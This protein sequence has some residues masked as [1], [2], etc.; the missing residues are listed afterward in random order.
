MW[1]PYVCV[2]VCLVF[3]DLSF[4]VRVR[5]LFFMPLPW[6]SHIHL[7]VHL[8]LPKAFVTSVSSHTDIDS[9]VMLKR[10]KNLSINPTYVLFCAIMPPSGSLEQPD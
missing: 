8:I 5:V 7:G 10:I 4:R 2:C 9:K 6:C 3:H 1:A